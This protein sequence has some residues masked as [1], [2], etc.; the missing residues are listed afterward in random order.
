VWKPEQVAQDITNG[1]IFE[2]LRKQTR[3]AIAAIP[4][5]E[6]LEGVIALL[7]RPQARN[8]PHI[9]TLSIPVLAAEYR[10]VFEV[11]DL[12][13]RLSVYEPCVGGS[14]PVIIAA[15]AF[16]SG[17]ANYLTVNLNR[18]L[19]AELQRKISHLES[20]IRI[21]DDNAQRVLS[22]LESNSVD[23]ACFHHAINDILQTAVSEPRGMDTATVDWW[24]NERQMIEWMAEDFESG[25]IEERGKKELMQIIGDAVKLVRPGGYLI[26]DHWTYLGHKELDWFPW[27]LFCDL[28]SVTRRWIKESSLSVAEVELPDADPQWWMFLRAEK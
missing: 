7:H 20:S 13:R 12:P 5:S 28:V 9:R 25:L 23:A 19:R 2:K 21:V 1:F 24:P 6:L 16:S 15:E 26:F 8:I 11:L 14:E 17:R 27:Q 3:E 22:Y 4:Q 10:D 18:Q